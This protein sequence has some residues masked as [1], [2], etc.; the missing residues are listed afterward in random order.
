M[1]NPAAIAS[2]F[3]AVRARRPYSMIRLGD[4]EAV[5]LSYGDDTWLQDLA[6]LHGH[7]GAE[8]VTLESVAETRR[9]LEAAVEGADLIG[10]RNDIID[11][12]IPDDL[13]DRTPSGI[14]DFVINNFH[15]RSD[16]VAKLSTRGAR[17]IALLHRA[18]SRVEWSPE[19]SFCSAWIH[20]EL[21]ATGALDEMLQETRHVGLV[22]ARPELA[23]M[24][25]RRFDVNV[26][27]VLVPDKVVEGAEPGSHVPDRYREMRSELQFPEGTLVLV[28][29]GIPGKA[30]CQWLKESGCVAIDV[31]SVFDAWVGK[32]SRPRVL[33]SRFGVHGGN[34]VPT[35]LQLRVPVAVEG[36]GLTPRWKPSKL[37]RQAE[38]RQQ[39]QL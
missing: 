15:L 27:P 39:G 31:G 29:A 34:H 25:A 1:S 19:Q 6:Y 30:Y 3:E 10:V 13:A 2:M 26:S 22:T 9:D 17:R 24:V 14:H 36:H 7:W 18:L 11:V 16:E 8:G 12:T 33:E 23:Q 38:T 21:L 32:A 35:K 28:G 20:W 4:G 37:S 5:V